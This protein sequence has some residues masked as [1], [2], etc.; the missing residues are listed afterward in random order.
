MIG[1][2]ITIY[3]AG[4]NKE[5]VILYAKGYIDNTTAP[6]IDRVIDEQLSLGLNKIIVNL[7]G[8]NYISSAGWGV[9]VSDLSEIR[10]NKGDI[11]L[12]NMSPNVYNVF[13]L[14]EFSSI[15][16]SFD[17]MDR[18]ISYFLGVEV[19][20]SETAKTQAPIANDNQRM[21]G[22]T[23]SPKREEVVVPP[24][25]KK[26]GAYTNEAFSLTNNDLGRKILK[27]IIDSPYFTAKEIT[28]ALKL[29]QYGGKRRRKIAVKRELK[30]MDLTDQRKRFE[31][32]MRNR[33]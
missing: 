5:V 16:K 12:V 7:E 19:S 28:R 27:V 20:Q 10:T 32:A 17:S 3:Y 4:T 18:A 9:F 8:V 15:L 30:F 2:E 24:S 14:M 22:S 1:I 13:E 25:P 29:P 23:T 31:F 11:V 6:D 33:P 26:A 21:A